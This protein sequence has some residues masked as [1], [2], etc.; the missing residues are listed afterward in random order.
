MVRC[1]ISNKLEIIGL[2]KDLEEYYRYKCRYNTSVYSSE[3]IPD[4]LDLFEKT[5]KGIRIPRGLLNEVYSLCLQRGLEI[6]IFNEGYVGEQQNFKINPNINYTSGVYGYQGK[7]VNELMQYT[8]ARLQ[9]MPGSGKTAMMCL[10]SALLNKGP[11]LYLANKQRLIKQFML[12]AEKVLNIPEKE[13]GIIKQ[14]KCIIKPLTCGSLQTMGKKDFDLGA[15]KNS[16]TSVYYDESHLSTALTYRRVLLGLAPQRLYGFSATPDHYSSEDLNH[17]MSALLGPVAV[18]VKDEEIP[19]RLIPDVYTR[20]TRHTFYFS[21]D[22]SSEQWRIRKQRH[23]LYDA[24]GNSVTRDNLIIGDALK[25]LSIGHKL[26]ICV[27]RVSHGKKLYQLLTSSGI[28]VSFP[29][30]IKKTKTGEYKAQ[31]DHKKLNEDVFEIERGNINVIIGTYK[32]FDTGFDCPSLSAIL[33]AA[34]FS[35]DN[36]TQIIQS[37]GRIQRFRIDKQHPIVIDYLDDSH[38]VNVLQHWG[39]KRAEFLQKT[40]RNYDIIR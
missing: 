11:C 20:F 33:Y 16:F 31:V 17:L 8:T 36:T 2:P 27:N 35:G 7:A 1:I 13:I 21:A 39:H 14:K 25:L 37:A 22:S 15:V 26:L 38:P 34:P 10:I 12:T 18:K 29:Y 6:K 4:P 40:Y 19:K 3:D 28:K 9:A 30:K 24:I 5:E 23:K 32:L